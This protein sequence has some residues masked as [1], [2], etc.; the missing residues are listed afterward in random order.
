MAAVEEVSVLVVE[1]AG[2]APAPPVAGDRTPLR[3]I[4]AFKLAKAGSLVGVAA[5]A[6]GLLGDALRDRAVQQLTVWVAR[7]AAAT[8]LQGVRGALG[9]TLERALA[10]LLRWL[11]DATPTRLEVTGVVALLYAA[12]LTAEGVG[13]WLA[14]PWAEW[15]SVGVTASLI[16]FEVWEVARR[17]TLL[18]VAVLV[19]NVAVVVYLARRVVRERAARRGRPVGAPPAGA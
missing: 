8:E 2:P 14:K 13:L 19:L 18:R 6:F 10:A 5:A 4:A 7:L 17:V 16:P 9:A 1:R 11:G 12:V 3:W 15:F